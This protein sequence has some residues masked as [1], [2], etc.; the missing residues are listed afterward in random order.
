MRG[1]SPAE[2][3]STQKAGHGGTAAG[4][5]D[6]GER[7]GEELNLSGVSDISMDSVS[8]GPATPTTT[9]PQTPPTPDEIMPPN[10]PTG[11]SD[12]SSD[13][14]GSSRSADVSMTEGDAEMKSADTSTS[15]VAVATPPSP[16][17]QGDA[18]EGETEEQGSAERDGVTSSDPVCVEGVAGEEMVGRGVRPPPLDSLGP[19]LAPSSPLSNQLTPSKTPGKRK[20]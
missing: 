15:S 11:V 19:F 13:T 12:I 17:P 4:S 10:N 16:A 9:G 7:E 18:R 6:Q 14:V 8:R 1:A 3:G 5:R 20:V 2:E